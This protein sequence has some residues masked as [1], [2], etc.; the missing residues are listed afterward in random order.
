MVLPL[1]T[2]TLLP[3]RFFFTISNSAGVILTAEVSSLI[4][5]FIRLSKD[6]AYEEVTLILP[7]CSARA[8][9]FFSGINPLAAAVITAVLI[10]LPHNL[11][12]LMYFCT[13][14]S[15]SLRMRGLLKGFFGSSVTFTVSPGYSYLAFFS[16]AL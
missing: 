4:T 9:L 12:S 8:H 11:I 2:F 6:L 7:P 14:S 13:S 10:T 5:K 15:I 16:N 3:G 1:A